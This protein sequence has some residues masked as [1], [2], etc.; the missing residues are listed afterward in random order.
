V[1]AVCLDEAQAMA[2]AAGALTPPEHETALAHVE[3][4]DSCRQ[5]LAALVRRDTSATSWA[6]GTRIGRYVV[7]ERI[8]KGGMGAVWR[9][10][11]LELRRPVA[12][13]RLHA[14]SESAR[15]LR[16]ARAA[17]QLQHPN[18]VAVYEVGEALGEPFL[19][20]ELVDGETLAAWRKSPRSLAQLVS[21]LAQAGR[22]LAAAHA[23]GLVHRDFKPENVLIDRSG[24]ARVVDFGLA[25]AGDGAGAAP[26]AA[27][28]LGRLTE[29]GAISGTPAYL[30][31]ELVDGAPP[32]ARSDQY[33]FAI[34]CYEALHGQ[35][36]FA[37][38]TAEV[39]WSEMAAGRVRDGLGDVPAWL[40]SHVR[41]GLA[42]D[43]AAR[44]PS[45]AA[46]VDA[47]EKRPR[48]RWP[49]LA[50]AGVVLAANAVGYL[51]FARSPADDC[52]R[53]GRV[54]D[55]VWNDRARD[56]L[57]HAFAAVAPTRSTTVVAAG[58]LAD[59]W[60]DGWK[61]GHDAA[62]HADAAERTA[63]LDCLD[64]GLGELRAQLAAWKPAD[65]S[66]V[67]GM[68]A[69][70][71]ALP[72]PELCAAHAAPPSHA[73]PQLMA[74]IDAFA[75]MHRSD[76]DRQARPLIPQLIADAEA[77]KDPLALARVLSASGSVERILGD[78]DHARE[79][80]GRA[81]REAA[82]AGDDRLT[83]MSITEEA[84]VAVDQGQPR[85]GLGLIDA[86]E[87][88]ETRSQ[89]GL[90]DRVLVVRADAM[91]ALG[92]TPE[93]IAAYHQ[94]ISLIEPRAVRDR[95]ARYQLAAAT[96][97]LGTALAEQGKFAEAAEQLRKCAA[98]E[99]AELGPDT[100]EYANTIHDLAN[101]ELELGQVDDAAAHYQQARAV[102]LAAYGP[103]H[104]LVIAS[105]LG[106]ASVARNR[107]QLPEAQ[108]LLE[109]LRAR[110]PD[111]PTIISNVEMN[112][113]EVCRE[114]DDDKDAIVHY[115]NALAASARAGIT[116]AAVGDIHANLALVLSNNNQG[117][118]ARREAEAA[119]AEYDRVN[120]EPGIR[121]NAWLVL[122]EVEHNAGH[123]AA[124]IAY[125][126]KV[127]AALG[128]SSRDDSRAVRK[129]AEESIAAWSK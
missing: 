10:E 46:M 113:A 57:V 95:N 38:G 44:W 43:P 80:L 14:G 1:D 33:A 47:I 8:G 115:R 92:R 56:E 15:L 32:D 4:C 6:P 102:I 36:P 118:E 106:L 3:D 20:M 23:S 74:R 24:R 121:V 25:R 50:A 129:E 88:L 12:L 51:V 41:R 103:D 2:F 70:V 69:A 11:D 66:E 62:C 59:D 98:I 30:A 119:L 73:S 21:V 67:D 18:V 112:L 87:A 127:I 91:S 16:E 100:P 105:D 94:A 52:E 72:R 107:H 34:T 86:A 89:L 101:Q 49:W 96:G 84:G 71:G 114:R 81:A 111:N 125:E 7:R 120:A 39:L 27:G 128:D 93:A 37:G 61:L 54:I 76:R 110:L 22:G 124:A 77:S 75:A 79:H 60:A 116:G 31:P 48:R 45:V 53:G 29:T 65:A 123:T 83:L 19:A 40:E 85:D 78:L 5:V 26:H 126:R 28:P 68:V 82:R 9:A 108:R 17:A 99:K 90:E 122:G 35:H 117:A 109:Q 55:T 104:E 64:R 58:R 13:K 63:R 42:A 97:A